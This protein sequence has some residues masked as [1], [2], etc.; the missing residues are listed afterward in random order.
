MSNQPHWRWFAAAGVVLNAVLFGAAF[1]SRNQNSEPKFSFKIWAGV[2][3]IA[4]FAGSLLGLTIEQ[5]LTE[6]FELGGLVRA[7]ALAGLSILQA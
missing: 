2:A 5:G 6:S 7:V 4:T 1:L 3:T